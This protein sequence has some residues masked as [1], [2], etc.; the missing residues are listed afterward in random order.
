MRL[1]NY[2]D[3][4]FRVLIYLAARQENGDLAT[5]R[6][7]SEVYSIS[8]NHLV[9]VVHQLSK[10]GY[11]ETSTG[12]NGGIRLGMPAA[13]INLG[14]IVKE[15]ETSFNLVDCHVGS[16]GCIIGKNCQLEGI[17]QKSLQAFLGEMSQYTL[18][19][20]T[21]NKRELAGIFAGY[22]K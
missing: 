7:I 13:R 20:I 16:K 12:K 14:T 11:L 3:Y 4:S 10:R 21:S 8:K 18:E 17:I 9:K 15:M 22:L 19:D 5:I 1:S 6:E 2:T